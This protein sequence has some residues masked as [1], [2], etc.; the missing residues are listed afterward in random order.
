MAFGKAKQ[1]GLENE[2]LKQQIQQLSQNNDQL[3]QYSNW[4]QGRIAQLEQLTSS[5]AKEHERAIS[6]LQQQVASWQ[7]ALE[8]YHAAYKNWGQ[9]ISKKQADDAA[10]AK[11]MDEKKLAISDLD[12]KIRDKS[13]QII[14]LDDDILVQ[15]FGLY[16]PRFSFQSVEQY[17]DKLKELREGQKSS[18]K[19]MNERSKDS[20]WTVN[21]SQ[22][23]GRKMV[24]DISKL[25]MTAFNG[26][27]DDIIRRV[28]FS[29]ID[30]SVAAIDKQ[31]AKISKYGR[32]IGIEIP[33]DYISLKKNEAY[34]SYE[35]AKFKEAEKE[36]MRELREQEREE[37]K[38]QK[39]I[40]DKR[41]KLEKER[42]QYKSELASVIDQMKHTDSSKLPALQEKKANLEKEL[43]EISKAVEDIDY[44]EAN[45]RAGF[46]YV[47]SNIGSFG[48]DVY[49]IGM[50]R[51][52]EPMDRVRELGDA[53]VPFGFDVHA[54]IFSDDAP[55]LEAALHREFADRKLNL[56]NQRR[57]FFRCTLEEIKKAI[58]KNYDK[59]VEFTDLPDAEQY[60]VSEK[61]RKA[62]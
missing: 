11:S 42:K 26:A 55:G 41:K 19:R 48:K 3:K 33:R 50:T 7:K 10:L 46:V 36:R 58:T 24:S 62:K 4:A 34:V 57:E 60:R 44:R 12:N 45:Q 38:L 39:E 13:A 59:T 6:E 16:K 25:L 21:G 22:S 27:C 61:M 51:R 28:K 14:S 32:T 18:I 53:S 15:D 1:L 40:A 17:K 5:D 30:A 52:L 9:A 54:M 2:Q 47:I 8:E 35:Y 23:E 20:T 43:G 29:N 37:K 56:V 49:K 31:A